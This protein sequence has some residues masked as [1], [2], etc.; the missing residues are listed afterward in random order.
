MSWLW[1]T[2]IGFASGAVPYS[3]LVG[4]LVLRQDI[5]RYGDHNP[6]A[7]NVLSAG[8][9]KGVFLAAALLDGFKGCIPVGLAYF[10]QGITGWELIPVALA[11]ALGHIFSP[12]LRFRGGKAIAVTFGIWAGL[13]VGEAP[14]FLGLLLGWWFFGV[15]SS[16]WAVT[17]SAISFL[18]YALLRWLP[19]NPVFVAIWAINAALLIWRYRADLHTSPAL[20]TAFTRRVDALLGRRGESERPVR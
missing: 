20:R 8:G 12:F 15:A 1:W 10:G 5:R 9:G 2:L 18:I 4:R 14:T 13:T 17:F 16:G 6:G 11:P 3:L 19:E 7:F